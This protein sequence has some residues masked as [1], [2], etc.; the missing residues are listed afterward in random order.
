MEKIIFIILSARINMSRLKNVSGGKWYLPLPLSL[1]M[2]INTFLILAGESTIH[3]LLL[4][5][6]TN[7]E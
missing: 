5:V 6:V 2:D 7:D 4:I 3:Y 1:P